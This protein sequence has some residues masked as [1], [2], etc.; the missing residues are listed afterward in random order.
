MGPL[1]KG[2]RSKPGIVSINL[3]LRSKPGIVSSI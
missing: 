1:L 2:L 3:G